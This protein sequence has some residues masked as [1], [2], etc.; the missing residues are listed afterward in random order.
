MKKF[1]LL[2]LVLLGLLLAGCQLRPVAATPPTRIAFTTDRDGVFEVYLMDRD[3]DNPRNLTNS[4]E[5]DGL[6]TWSSPT[7][8]FAFVTDR[9][10]NNL[11]VYRMDADGS[12]P[13]KL[14]QDIVA[15]GASPLWS[16]TG[17]WLAF[18]SGSVEESDI[19]VVDAA[20]REVINLT[21]RPGL[22]Y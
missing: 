22:D 7:R 21:N 13:T 10:G 18:G 9:E 19:Y 20:G 16:P 4:Q 3:G 15:N 14:S 12:H 17:E 1:R 8:T 5:N 2:L 6:P 11:S